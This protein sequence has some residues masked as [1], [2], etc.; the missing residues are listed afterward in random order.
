[1]LWLRVVSSNNNPATIAGLYL[2]ATE[3]LE[4]FP[5]CVRTDCG[6]ENGLLAAAQ[7]Y[8]N[9]DHDHKSHLYGSS[10]HNQR[11]ESWW[12]Q[13]RKLKS[14]FIM[15]FFKDMV[16]QGIYNTGNVFHKS[17]AFYCFAVLIQRELDECREQWNCHYI[18]ASKSSE[19][20]GRPDY[21]HFVPPDNFI[22]FGLKVNGRDLRI[23][24]E[25]I[26][27]YSIPEDLELQNEMISYFDYLHNFLNLPENS[28]FDVARENFMRLLE[29]C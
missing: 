24:N 28:T 11:I 23:L 9:R 12:S 17:C 20:F 18:R 4:V 13:F 8:F 15:D 25:H 19:A 26:D 14:N 2:K 1:M 7:C 21:L 27:E 5:R 22:N 6:T 16:S 3:D 29:L 10:N